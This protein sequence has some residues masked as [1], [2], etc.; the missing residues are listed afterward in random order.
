MPRALIFGTAVTT[1]AYTAA[2]AMYLYVLPIARMAVVEENRVAAAVASVLLGG[3]GVTLV[4]TA[5]LVSTFGCANGLILAGARVL[6]AMSRDGV[7]VRS[8][9]RIDPRRHT[10]RGALLL[11][12]VWSCVLALSGSYDRLLTYV[13]FASLSFNMLTVLGLFVLR[14]TRSDVSRPYRTWGYPVTP[15]VYLVGSLF[16]LVYIFIGDPRDACAG[17]GLV[18]VGVPAYGLFRRRSAAAA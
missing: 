14:R 1:L 15:A 17:L 4:S 18:A 5:I 13:I 11:Q 10:P 16:L 7:F 12:G 9:G 2:C 6:Y 8:A 3:A